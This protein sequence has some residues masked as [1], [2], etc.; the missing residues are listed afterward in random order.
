M[1]AELPVIIVLH[2]I[3]V[4]VLPI[5]IPHRFFNPPFDEKERPATFADR[6]MILSNACRY[7]GRC[8]YLCG[9]CHFLCGITFPL[10]FSLAFH[11]AIV[12]AVFDIHSRGREYLSTIRTGAITPPVFRRLAA[13]KFSPTVGTAEPSVGYT[14]H[15]GFPAL[16][17]DSLKRWAH[18]FPRL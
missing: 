6:S 15:E 16:L 1:T 10:H 12:R 2:N 9:T 5:A 14:S 11:P 17:T 8:D 13:V 18:V 4:L 7:Y 3:L